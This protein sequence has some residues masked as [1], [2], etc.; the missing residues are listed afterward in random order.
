MPDDSKKRQVRQRAK[1][2]RKIAVKKENDTAKDYLQY[3]LVVLVILI[4][5][6]GAIYITQS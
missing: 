1:R 6:A 4:I 5:L 2:I 3:T